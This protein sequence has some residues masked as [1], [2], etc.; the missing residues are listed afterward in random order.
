MA[1]RPQAPA[2][3]SAAKRQTVTC[4]SPS[5]IL[6]VDELLLLLCRGFLDWFA[7]AALAMERSPVKKW[8][9]GRGG[10]LCKGWL[11][12]AGPHFRS[13]V[14]RWVEVGV[15]PPISRRRQLCRP[16]QGRQS[17]DPGADCD[18]GA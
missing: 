17:Q 1:D 10:A 15:S 4:S 5:L 6:P 16:L 9:D 11:R 2:A 12:R 7:Q 14:H 18:D 13:S 3:S 8:P